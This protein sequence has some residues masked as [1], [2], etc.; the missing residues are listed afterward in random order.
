MSKTHPGI[1]RS[2]RAEA[3]DTDPGPP[4]DVSADSAEQRRTAV[5][6]LLEM[7]V[8]RMPVRVVE[9]ASSE[10][11]S[12]VQYQGEAH[13]PPRP[14]LDHATIPNAKVLL[15]VTQPHVAGPR[16]EPDEASLERAAAAAAAGHS[17]Q[18]Q[19]SA[20][21]APRIDRPDTGRIPMRSRTWLVAALGFAMAVGIGVL[22]KL[23]RTPAAVDEPKPA[24]TLSSVI[25]VTAAPTLTQAAPTPPTPATTSTVSEPAVPSTPHVVPSGPPTA[26]SLPSALPTHTAAAP[27]TTAKPPETA[28]S[29]PPTPPP[30]ASAPAIPSNLPPGVIRINQ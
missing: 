8:G 28:H 3:A 1:G 25:A 7:P 4:P 12:A 6:E 13:L 29:A 17:P 22:I 30:T 19:K 11:M 18:V 2:G 9:R 27:T 24:P 26:R 21:T 10:G 14:R 15:N 5:N 23:S 16:P 20:P